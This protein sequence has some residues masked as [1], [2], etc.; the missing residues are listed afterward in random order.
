MLA[1]VHD[2]KVK[3]MGRYCWAI[4]PGC[5]QADSWWGISGSRKHVNRE[6]AKHRGVR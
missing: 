1:I 2:P 5:F 4:C 6:A 3:G